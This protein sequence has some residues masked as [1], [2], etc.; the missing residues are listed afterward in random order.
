[1]NC[2]VLLLFCGYFFVPD[3]IKTFI[4][5]IQRTQKRKCSRKPF[6]KIK[7]LLLGAQL[8]RAPLICAM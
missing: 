4:T 6:A 8:F 2:N 5:L 3:L 1:M 7:R